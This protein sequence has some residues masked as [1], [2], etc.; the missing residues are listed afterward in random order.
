M[1]SLTNSRQVIIMLN[2]YGHMIGYNL[3]EEL[4]TEMTNASV[5]DNEVVT[6]GISAV[7]GCSTNVA[8]YNFHRFINTN[9]GNDTMLCV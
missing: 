5:Q 3:A 7:D 2:R 9:S 6:T 1:K 4:E 8:F